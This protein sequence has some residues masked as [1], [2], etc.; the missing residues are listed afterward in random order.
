MQSSN[1]QLNAYY[2]ILDQILDRFSENK[3]QDKPILHTAFKNWFIREHNL[4]YDSLKYFSMND[5]SKFIDSILIEFSVEYG[6]YLK[7]PND[8]DNAEDISLSEY[9]EY[10]NW[11]MQDDINLSDSLKTLPEGFVLIKELN[12]LKTLKNG[13]RTPKPENLTLKIGTPIYI[14]SFSH[15]TYYKKILSNYTPIEKLEAY[16]QMQIVYAKLENN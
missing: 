8:P 11:I 12:E 16:I 4:P 5:M 10:K 1:K 3:S 15:E 2:F 13:K 9:L 7:Q 14:Y 6:I